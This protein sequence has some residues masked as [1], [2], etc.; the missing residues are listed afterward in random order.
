MNDM[1]VCDRCGRE[2]EPVT[3]A[4]RATLCSK[5]ILRTHFEA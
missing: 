4:V 2:V 3:T 1:T 5:C